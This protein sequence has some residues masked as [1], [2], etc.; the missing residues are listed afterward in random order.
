MSGYVNPG[1]LAA[2]S[3][4]AWERN[5]RNMPGDAKG[6]GPRRASRPIIVEVVI[7][8]GVLVA[9]ATYGWHVVSPDV[10]AEA[11]EGGMRLSTAESRRLFGIEVSFGVV[12]AAAGVIA[13]A[14]LMT[15]H[16]REAVLVQVLLA[17]TGI[18]GA[19]LVWLVGR[20]TGPGDPAVHGRSAAPGTMLEMPLDVESYAMFAIWPIAAV[21]AGAVVIAIRDRPPEP[22]HGGEG[23]GRGQP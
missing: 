10:F 4:S 6:S 18:V 11:T 5:A 8:T 23:L 13:G 21:V 15:R 20:G 17:G 3:P 12:T 9:L 16:R 14:W 1:G 7:V 2:A 19:V 22:G